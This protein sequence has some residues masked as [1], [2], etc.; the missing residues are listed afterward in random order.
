[1]ARR[2]AS[3]LEG[4]AATTLRSRAS[5]TEAPGQSPAVTAALTLSSAE[6]TDSAW[7]ELSSELLLEPHPAKLNAQIKMPI[8]QPAVER[9]ERIRELM[10]DALAEA[11]RK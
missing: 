6:L 1:L 8:R 10:L 9:R 5:E 7:F 2:A 11:N 3:T 4:R